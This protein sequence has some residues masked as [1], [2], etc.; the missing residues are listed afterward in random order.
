[1]RIV[2]FMMAGAGVPVLGHCH[3]RQIVKMHDFYIS[4]AIMQTNW[5]LSNNVHGSL[6]QNCKFHG[7]RGRSSCTRVWRY[8]SYSNNALFF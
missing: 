8:W 4:L 6:H 1:M 7:P 5:T 3:I 2:N